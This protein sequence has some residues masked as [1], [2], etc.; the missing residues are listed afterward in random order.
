MATYNVDV[1]KMI[2]VFGSNEAGIHGAGA[3][4]YAYEKRLARWGDSY[5]MTG[6]CFAI[7]TKGFILRNEFGKVQRPYVG[8][9]LPLD[10]I[11]LY[12]GG[13]LAYARAHQEQDFQITCIGCGLAGLRHEDVAP[14]FM[15]IGSFDNMYFDE[16]W[17][18]F[19]GSKYQ[20]W[21]DG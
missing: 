7:P 8:A 20:Y 1:S 2:M 10:Q 4:R 18:P 17:R 19:L 13:F 21:G 16:K 5:G 11:K 15:Q 12:V 6:T 3:A 9:T 14:L